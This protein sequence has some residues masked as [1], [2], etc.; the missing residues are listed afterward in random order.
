[1][2]LWG[3]WALI[4]MRKKLLLSD[5]VW[6]HH[7]LME[8]LVKTRLKY[9]GNGRYVGNKFVL[10]TTFFQ[11]YTLRCLKLGFNIKILNTL[12]TQLSLNVK[13]EGNVI[14]YHPK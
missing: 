10:A 12:N 5:F 11:L 14:H 4:D 9:K 7:K 3:I 13:L 2:L 1:M 6:T 8:N